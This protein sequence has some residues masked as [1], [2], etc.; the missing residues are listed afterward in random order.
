MKSIV[1]LLL[2]LGVMMVTTG[3]H[4]KMQ[5]TFKKEKVIEYRYIPRS[6]FEEQIQP[7]NL[8]QSFN[9]MFRKDNV[10]IG[11]R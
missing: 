5:E 6:L 1:L 9:D 7:V 11:R 8:Q 3:Y 4:Q 2:V 10:F